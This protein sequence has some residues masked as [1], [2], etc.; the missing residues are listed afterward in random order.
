[1]DLKAITK[2]KSDRKKQLAGGIGNVS[3]IRRPVPLHNSATAQKNGHGDN[4]T[5]D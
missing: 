4:K 2:I 5:R 1:M 3:R